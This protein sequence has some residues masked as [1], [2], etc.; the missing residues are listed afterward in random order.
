M[1]SGKSTQVPQFLAEDLLMGS[2]NGLVICTQVYTQ[3]LIN[4]AYANII[5]SLD[6]SQ[7]CQSQVEYLLRWVTHPKLLAPEMH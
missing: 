7:P 6:V 4:I 1:Y 3:I 2:S 5:K